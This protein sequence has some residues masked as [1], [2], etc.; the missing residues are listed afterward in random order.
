VAR[1]YSNE[2]IALQV[3]MEL[4]RLDNDV[5]TSLE[6][7]NAN[8][9]VPDP[10]VLSFASSRQRILLT[11]NRR[12]FLQLHLRRTEK[13]CGIVLCTF[14]ADFTGLAHRIDVA[15]KALPNSADQ[16]IR[17]NRRD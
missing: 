10:E 17:V 15:V 16:L 5:L 12:H 8:A 1:F 6:A 9:S 2:N 7:G 11:H 13:H 4:R 14:D 3:V